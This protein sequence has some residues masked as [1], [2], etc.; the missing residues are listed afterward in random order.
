MTE[1]SLG[2]CSIWNQYGEKRSRT[3][4]FF[5]IFLFN[6][7]LFPPPYPPPLSLPLSEGGEGPVISEV[8]FFKGSV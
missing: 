7:I 1:I 6:V 2:I 3:M 8:F 5:F 4:G